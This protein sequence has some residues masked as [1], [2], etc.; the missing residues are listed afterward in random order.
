MN[1]GIETQAVE[2]SSAI[3][4]AKNKRNTESDVHV[5]QAASASDPAENQANVESDTQIREE[6]SSAGAQ[7]E[8]EMN[9]ESAAEAEEVSQDSKVP[10]Q[11]ISK[12]SI[13]PLDGCDVISLSSSNAP[14]VD[15]P[16]KD[17]PNESKTPMHPVPTS[18]PD[19][20][21]P[22]TCFVC[23]VAFP[24]SVFRGHLK[25][26]LEMFAAGRKVVCP[27]C[28][29]VCPTAEKMIDHAFLTHG[30]VKKLLCDVDAM[31]VATFWVEDDLKLHQRNQH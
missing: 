26:E 1:V 19:S 8:K 15:F 6:A 18:Y 21:L 2:A 11:D 3:T 9:V 20:S 5:V 12:N 17:E 10:L 30:K 28:Q 23:S 27:E 24:E 22:K 4:Q 14:S 16:L 31:C 25:Q 13:A 7:P 29:I